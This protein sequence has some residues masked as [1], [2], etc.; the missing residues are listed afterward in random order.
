[1]QIRLASGVVS[2]S[3]LNNASNAAIPVSDL[4]TPITITIPLTRPLPFDSKRTSILIS[5]VDI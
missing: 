1:L 3:L 4:S 2:L 5:K